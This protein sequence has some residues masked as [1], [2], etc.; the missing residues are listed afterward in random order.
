MVV[1]NEEDL[2]KKCTEVSIECGIDIANKLKQK[3]S[4]CSNGVGLSAPQIGI[5]AR[6]FVAK[7]HVGILCFVNPKIVKKEKPFIFKNEGCLS[8]P[9]LWI[10]T[11]R[12]S[13]VEIEDEINGTTKA[14]NFLSIICQ[15]E[16][17]HLDG[18]IFKDR[19]VPE[20]YSKCF[21]GSGNKFKFCCFSKL[22]NV[23]FE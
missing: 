15:H 11:I 23:I 17:D 10:D 5:P 2:R 12:Y 19:K 20:R 8:F 1:Q 21:C 9:G 7:S 6:V 4:N 13:S 16:I 22:E 3:L 18:I 14:N